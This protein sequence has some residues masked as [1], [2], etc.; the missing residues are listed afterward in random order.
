MPLPLFKT[1][2]L[3]ALAAI[4]LIF[5]IPAVISNEVKEGEK[6]VHKCK[7]P[8]CDYRGINELPEVHNEIDSIHFVNPTWDYNKCEGLIK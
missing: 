1:T 8:G 2:D 5:S 7:W 4:V 6:P 3:A